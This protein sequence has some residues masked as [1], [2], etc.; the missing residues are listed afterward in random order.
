MAAYRFRIG[1]KAEVRAQARELGIE[2]PDIFVHVNRD[3]SLGLATGEAPIPWPEGMIMVRSV[4]EVNVTNWVATG[5]SVSIP[6]YQFDLQILWTDND[7]EPHEHN[8]T[9]RYPND[10]AAM[11]LNVRRRY[12]EEMVVATARVTLGIDEWSDYS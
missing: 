9:Y 10:I 7:G 4:E 3:G 11:P 6:Q 12:A 2:L 1:I 5:S 8:G